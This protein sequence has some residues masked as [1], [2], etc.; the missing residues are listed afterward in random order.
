MVQQQDTLGC[1]LMF[2]SHLNVSGC[3]TNIVHLECF[4]HFSYSYEK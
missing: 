2:R 4:D 1:D 3:C